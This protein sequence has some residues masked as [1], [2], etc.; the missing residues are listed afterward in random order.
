[1]ENKGKDKLVYSGQ[2]SQKKVY[3]GHLLPPLVLSK[4]LAKIGA[5]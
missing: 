4:L 5:M 1:M 2:V 3:L